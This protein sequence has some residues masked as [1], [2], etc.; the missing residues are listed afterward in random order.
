MPGGRIKMGTYG[1]P[2]KRVK[3]RP[4]KPKKKK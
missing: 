3:K 4:K 2:T 1:S